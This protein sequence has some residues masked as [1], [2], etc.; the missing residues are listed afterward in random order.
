MWLVC[1]CTGGLSKLCLAG[2]DRAD[3]QGSG[4]CNRSG[5][6]TFWITPACRSWTGS[7]KRNSARAGAARRVANSEWLTA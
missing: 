2:V 5:L 6:N 7:G 3:R 1:Q 4:C